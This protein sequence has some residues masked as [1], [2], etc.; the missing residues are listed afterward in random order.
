MRNSKFGNSKYSVFQRGSYC[1]LH[2]EMG[3]ELVSNPR[4]TSAAVQ[5]L[6][7]AAFFPSDFEFP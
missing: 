5:G 7:E 2:T 3:Q 1:R 4:D 6:R